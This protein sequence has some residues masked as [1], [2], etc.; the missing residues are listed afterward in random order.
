MK[1]EDAKNDILKLIEMDNY[2]FLFVLT[3]VV[4]TEDNLNDIWAYI[5][6][7]GQDRTN[8][9]RDQFF[10][11]IRNSNYREI[12]FESTIKNI[13]E[14][15]NDVIVRTKK[16]LDQLGKLKGTTLRYIEIAKDNRISVNGTV[17]NKETI[18]DNMLNQLNVNDQFTST[19]LST[20]I[21]YSGISM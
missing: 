14:K 10:N 12:S 1:I 20:L 13:S 15:K 9:E 5:L 3:D 17:T 4:P 6:S 19:I 2:N 16:A 11:D 7:F 21:F 8:E 18:I